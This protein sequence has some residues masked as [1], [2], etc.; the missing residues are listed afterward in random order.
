LSRFKNKALAFQKADVSKAGIATLHQNVDGLSQAH[1][2]GGSPSHAFDADGYEEYATTTETTVHLN[3]FLL[4]TK[5]NL[6]FA[7]V[8]FHEYRHSFQYHVPYTSRR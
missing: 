2:D 4:S 6:F 1:E 5:N 3:K 8:L 7:G